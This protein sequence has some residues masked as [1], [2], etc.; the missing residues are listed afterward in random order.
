MA[1][2]LVTQG[3]NRRDF[4]RIAFSAS[5]DFQ[6]SAPTLGLDLTSTA[7]YTVGHSIAAPSYFLTTVFLSGALQKHC[8]LR[9]CPSAGKS[10]RVATPVTVH[11]SSRHYPNFPAK[12]CSFSTISNIHTMI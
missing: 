11:L 12:H 1:G 9:S 7:Q 8:G 6:V 5:R 3:L 10:P 4:S 2:W